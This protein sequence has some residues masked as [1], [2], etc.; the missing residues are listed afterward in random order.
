MFDR[1]TQSGEQ[2][3]ACAREEARRL[4][5]DYL[6]TEHLLLGVLGAKEG[7]GA[8]ILTA[9]GLTID[10]ARA[11]VV[12]IVGSEDDKEGRGAPSTARTMDVLM[13]AWEEARQHNEVGSEHILLAL[14]REGEGVAARVLSQANVTEA[15]VRAGLMRLRGLGAPRAFEPPRQSESEDL[16]RAELS[17]R[18]LKDMIQQLSAEEQETECRRRSLRGKRDILRAELLNRRRQ[19]PDS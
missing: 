1:F 14:L 7:R 13:L 18:E 11:Q 2:A 10:E 19:P 3:M 12:G 6:G 4:G 16:D 5:Q 9:A 8:E 15:D 17:E